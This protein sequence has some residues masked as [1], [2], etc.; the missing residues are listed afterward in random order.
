[1]NGRS[2][3]NGRF[4]ALSGL[5]YAGLIF[6]YLCPLWLMGRDCYVGVDSNDLFNEIILS[7]DVGRHLQAGQFPLF[8]DMLAYPHQYSLLGGFKSYLHTLASLPFQALL[9]WPHWWNAT[10]AFALW[11]N[12]LLTTLALHLLTRRRLLSAALGA[13]T[14]FSMWNSYGT[15]E[16]HLAQM[17]YGPLLLAIASLRLVLNTEQP[18]SLWPWGRAMWTL[19]LSSLAAALIYWPHAAFL[20]LLAVLWGAWQRFRLS[21]ARWQQLALVA[22]AGVCLLAP[23]AR[24]V[25]D[26]SEDI[27]DLGL[28]AESEEGAYGR[29][30]SNSM[31]FPSHLADI[32]VPLPDWSLTALILGALLALGIWCW[33][34]HGETELWVL[35]LAL[36]LLFGAGPCLSWGGY[37]LCQSPNHPLFLPFHYLQG[38]GGLFSR[39]QQPWA[40]TPLVMVSLYAAALHSLSQRPTKRASG[41]A[42]LLWV[43]VLGS[44]LLVAVDR[45]ALERHIAAVNRT[46]AAGALTAIPCSDCPHLP[47]IE[48][49]AQ[50]PRGAV[51]DLPL[52]FSVNVWH[53]A[54]LHGH[55]QMNTQP[56]YANVVGHPDAGDLGENS[57]LLYAL[58]EQIAACAPDKPALPPNAAAIGLRYGEHPLLREG[59]RDEAVWQGAL[60]HLDKCGHL[61][62]EAAH[63]GQERLQELGVRYLMLHRSACYWLCPSRGGQ[64][65]RHLRDVL[66]RAGAEL[67]VEDEE[68]SLWRWAKP[69]TSGVESP[70]DEPN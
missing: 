6:L 69:D 60:A 19:L 11:I 16:G 30:F 70:T 57:W 20:V 42:I 51:L 43:I 23:L 10:V 48:T 44:S 49:L 35:T 3:S 36:G 39:W 1:M 5:V 66:S 31:G 47:H 54:F 67:L 4:Y 37:T 25:C 22:V 62:E 18:R 55:P 53:Y 65:Y 24:L 8:S 14:I 33:R 40:V 52:Y 26:Y 63:R 17:W 13:L 58:Q 32:C 46:Y 50:L 38:L 15:M 34:R 7:F 21:V 64:V 45:G 61:G 56:F 29:A 2:L 59:E 27:I 68:A 41:L 28:F 9:P 12:A